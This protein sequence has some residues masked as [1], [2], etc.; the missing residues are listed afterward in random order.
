MFRVANRYTRPRNRWIPSTPVSVQSMSRSG[1][2]ANSANSRAVSAPWLSATPIASTT[3]PFDF[4]I[5]MPFASTIPCVKS[6]RTGSALVISPIS[7][8]IFV[9][10]RE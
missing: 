9:Q 2:A 1:G 5:F 6:F 10:K 4:D 7:R 3:L 8:I